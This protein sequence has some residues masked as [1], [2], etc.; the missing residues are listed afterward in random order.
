[1]SSKAIAAA[2]LLPAKMIEYRKTPEKYKRIKAMLDRVSKRTDEK[3]L[4]YTD[5]NIETIG[6][7]VCYTLLYGNLE[8]LIFWAQV[9]VQIGD[10]CDRA[11]SAQKRYQHY[12]RKITLVAERL[13]ERH[14]QLEREILQL[15]QDVS[16]G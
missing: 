5:E 1:M 7:M 10:E 3:S 8:Q 6:T 15:R 13:V 4:P 14:Q 11:I 2:V 12:S 16:R 9:L